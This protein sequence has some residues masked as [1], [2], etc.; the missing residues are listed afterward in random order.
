MALLANSEDEFR[1]FAHEVRSRILAMSSRAGTPH[2][3]G[4][5]SCVELLVATYF[6]GKFRLS[7]QQITDG[8][9]DT[10]IFSKGHAVSA[11]YAVLA[12]AGVI[13]SVELLTYNV[14]GGRLPEQPSVHCVPGI[15]WA[16]GSL[17]HGLP[18]GVGIALARKRKGDDRRVVV[19]MSDGECQEGSVW[20][21]AMLASHHQLDN[22]TVL[23]DA[24]GWQATD[25]VKNVTDL[26]PLEAKWSSFG[27]QVAGVDGRSAT[28]IAEAVATSQVTAGR[29]SAIVVHTVKGQGVSF[30]EDDNNW[31]YRSPTTAEVS[32]ALSE[33]HPS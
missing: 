28:A 20:E 9:S 22:L 31:H 2:V 27:W 16:T 33:I 8:S 13:E 26:Y 1:V 15:A 7:A 30:M 32:Q 19:I 25:R 12:V 23:V 21:A 14:N 11:V 10:V 29:P 4:A 24:N 6:G 17:G 3:A 18:V 5:L